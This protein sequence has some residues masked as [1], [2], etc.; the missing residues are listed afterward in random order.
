DDRF[1]ECCLA[2]VGDGVERAI[3]DDRRRHVAEFQGFET[4]QKRGE[5]DGSPQ[6]AGAHGASLG[7]GRTCSVGPSSVPKGSSRRKSDMEGYHLSGR[8]G[9]KAEEIR[10]SARAACATEAD[11]AVDTSSRGLNQR[12]PCGTMDARIRV[13]PGGLPCLHYC[14]SP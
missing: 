13:P 1:A 7:C 12:D 2:V 11:D 3:D 9:P 6:T 4:R 5:A 10:A 8:P 14:C